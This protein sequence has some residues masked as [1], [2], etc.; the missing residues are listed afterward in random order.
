MGAAALLAMTLWG[1][2]SRDRTARPF[3][4]PGEGE[5]VTVEVLNGTRVDGLAR[6]ITAHLREQGIDVV[7]FGS[8]FDSTL[9]STQVLIRRGDSTAA[10]RVQAAL[11]TGRIVHQPDAAR[12]VDVTV[13]LRLDAAG[14]VRLHP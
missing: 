7:Y 8:A 14:I 4:I 3:P 13:I 6:T 2:L 11:G 5:A 9:D 12:M 1:I 10:K